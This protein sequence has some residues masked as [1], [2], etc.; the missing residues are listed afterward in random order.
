MSSMGGGAADGLQEVLRRKF[1]EAQA[2]QAARERER[3]R[4]DALAR[5]AENTRRW[6]TDHQLRVDAATR[7]TGLD[8]QNA[9][10]EAAEKAGRDAALAAVMND[11]TVPIQARNLIALGQYGLGANLNVHALESPDA[12]QAHVATH[13]KAEDD[14]KFGS[15]KRERDYEEQLRRSR[16]ALSGRLVKVDPTY[17][18]GVQSHVAQIRSRHPDFESAVQEFVNS[19]PLHQQAHPNFQPQK[20]IDALRNMYA[21]G[22]RPSAGGGGLDD[23]IAQAVGGGGQ[24]PATGRGAGS[25]V[26]SAGVPTPVA[27]PAGAKVATADQLAQLAQKHGLTVEQARAKAKALG[28]VVQ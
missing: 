27:P 14:R 6:N 10:A 24:I 13:A 26:Q 2:I 23:L 25:A 19:I 3:A 5:D 18:A 11:P 8:K 28:Y 7:L 15:W 1:L 12:H 4:Q 22:G 21:G 9:D 16:P 20:A 17:P